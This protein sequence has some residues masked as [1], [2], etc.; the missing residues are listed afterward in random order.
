MQ[1]QMQ[2]PDGLII[3]VPYC[4][5]SCV[6]CVQLLAGQYGEGSNESERVGG[7]RRRTSS[8]SQARS[9]ESFFS[10]SRS[11]E[12]PPSLVSTFS[13]R[14]VLSRSFLPR[15]STVQVQVQ[16]QGQGSRAGALCLASILSFLVFFFLVTIVT[17]AIPAAR[18]HR[19]LLSASR[20][21]PS[22]FAL[23][24]AVISGWTHSAMLPITCYGRTARQRWVQTPVQAV[25]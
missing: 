1:M 23:I 4:F 21:V 17:A 3:P 20:C 9:D 11:S 7:T 6:V 12:C 5:A 10:F 15:Q 18:A 24:A 14:T 13:H 16:V 19:R 25:P 8:P 22:A 2:V